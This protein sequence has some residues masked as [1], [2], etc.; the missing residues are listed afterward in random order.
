MGD[1]AKFFG[2]IVL[3]TQREKP[4][5]DV[6]EVRLPGSQVWVTPAAANGGQH[7]FYDDSSIPNSSE[8]MRLK[9][10]KKTV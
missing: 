6:E 5:Y 3:C 2:R 10:K 4:H 1:E 8:K 7:A 9:K